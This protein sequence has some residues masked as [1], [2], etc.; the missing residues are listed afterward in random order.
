V[1]KNG[2]KIVNKLIEWKKLSERKNLLLHGSRQVRKA[3]TALL[4]GA[5][6]TLVLKTISDPYRCMQ[7]G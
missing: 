2:T 4:F 1:T 3:Y 7:R 6:R 5:E